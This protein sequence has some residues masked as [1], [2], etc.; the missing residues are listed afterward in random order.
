MLIKE[1][2]QKD[3]DMDKEHFT[4]KIVNSMMG[5]R[6]KGLSDRCIKVVKRIFVVFD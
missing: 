2:G 5:N 6:K 3:Y 4:T 1:T